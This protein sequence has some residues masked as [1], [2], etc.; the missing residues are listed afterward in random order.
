MQWAGAVAAAQAAAQ[1]NPANAGLQ[2]RADF[3]NF[4]ANGGDQMD[5]SDSEDEDVQARFDWY[6]MQWPAPQDAAGPERA[7]EEKS[8]D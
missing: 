1:A 4:L 8:E 5:L 3:V 6:M 7:D 2:Q